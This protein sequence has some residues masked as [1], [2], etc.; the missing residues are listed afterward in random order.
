MN[1]NTRHIRY[2]LLLS[3]L[4]AL[5]ACVMTAPSIDGDKPIDNSSNQ[6]IPYPTVEQP[7]QFPDGD[8]ALMKIIMTNLHYPEKLN[9]NPQGRIVVQFVVNKDGSIG[10]VNISNSVDEELGKEIIRIV[11]S[12]PKFLPGRQNGNPVTTWYTLPININIKK[13]D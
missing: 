12:F 10:D 8:A 11:K 1:R 13:Q 5:G 2:M 6:D 3:L 7:P 4:L 9:E